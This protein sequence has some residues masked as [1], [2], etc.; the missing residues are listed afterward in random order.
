VSA[1]HLTPALIARTIHVIDTSNILDLVCPAPAAN[2]PGRRGNLRQNT[3]LLLIGWHLAARLGMETTVRGAHQVLTE[4]LPRA[5]QWDLGVL[6]PLTSQNHRRHDAYDPEAPALTVGG[7]PRKRIWASQGVEEIG[8]DDLAN[9]AQKLRDRLNYGPGSAPD[10]D[11]EE[12]ASRKKIVEQ[13]VDA[14]IAISSIERTGS[15]WAIDATGQWAWHRGGEKGRRRLEKKLAE[16]G[17]LD[18]DSDTDEDLEVA[19][20][21]TDEDGA[22]APEEGGAVSKGLAQRC[23]DA[24][25]GYKTS[26]TGKKEVGFG[27]HQHTCVSVPDPDAPADSEPL[28]VGGFALTP[29]N[30][31]VVEASLSVVDRILARHD[32]RLLLGDLLYTNLK[33]ARWA[34]PLAARG[35]EQALDMRSDNHKKV[36]IRGAWLLHGWM[37]CPAA[38][39]DSRPIPTGPMT[40]AEWEV[41]GQE[42]EQFQRAWAFDRK[43]SGL[44]K[45]RTTKWMCPAAVNRAGCH[46]RG[47]LQ[48]QSAVDRGLPIITPPADWATRKCCTNRVIDFTP[49]P[50]N[51]HHQRKLMQ[52]EYYAT[53]RWRHMF[54]RRALVEGTFGI[55]KNPSRQ[56]MRRGQNRLPGLAIASLIA[57]IK[58]SVYNEEQLRAWHDRTG[59]GPADHPLLQPDPTYWGYRDLTK[60]EAKALDAER[61]QQLRGPALPAAD[62]AA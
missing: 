59:R 49:D 8:Y 24:Q 35:I 54:K 27:F 20:I 44:G 21:A 56:R 15:T 11:P 28:L 62:Q 57:A 53:R 25:W 55:L 19:E 60:D 47:A 26:K 22:T 7:K 14:L 37:H 4:C 13:A 33:P 29:A 18:G 46:A 40:P 42:A 9:A 41:L 6:R 50:A 51:P 45:N 30:A 5:T 31:D 2:Q 16:P 32:V 34:L 3:R 10:L 1:K 43:E 58:I 38:P 39:I 23:L 52:R 12:R 61:L 48:V 36:D 17:F